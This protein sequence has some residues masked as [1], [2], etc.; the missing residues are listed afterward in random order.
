[1]KAERDSALIIIDVQ[2]DFCPNGSLA[3]AS[4][5]AVIPVINRIAP[6]FALVIATQDWHPE[7]HISFAVNHKG[8]KPFDTALVAGQV[9]VLWPVHC[10][11]GTL[12]ADFHPAL[13]RVPVSLIVHKGLRPEMDSYSA[14]FE[15][16]K[17]TSTGLDGF[18][19]GLGV[20][21]LYLTGLATDYCVL[22]TALDALALGYE[23]K[24]VSDAVRGV[25]VPAG[26]AA[27]ALETMQVK[28]AKLVASGEII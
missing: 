1:M 11:A 15:N 4:G 24:I 12:G 7:S 14:F 2:N 6:L 20:K 22:Y 23:V 18:L 10:V 21:S 13:D 9:Q 28:G 26:S 8:K 27:K 17:K 25:D 3:V 19:Q 5:D 16:D